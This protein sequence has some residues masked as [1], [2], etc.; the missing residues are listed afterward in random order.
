MGDSGNGDKDRGNKGGDGRT[1]DGGCGIRQETQP[2]RG[3]MGGGQ[4]RTRGG[5]GQECRVGKGCMRDVGRGDSARRDMK[6]G[7]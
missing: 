6:R 3:M 2:G 1:C 7:R 5:R 4:H